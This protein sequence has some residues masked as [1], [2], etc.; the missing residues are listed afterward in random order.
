MPVETAALERHRVVDSE[1][2]S[3]GT[4]FIVSCGYGLPDQ[5][6]AIVE[7]ERMTECLPGEIGEIWLSSPSVA[8]GYWNRSEETAQTFKAHLADTN[9]G[10]YLR[11]GDLGF[12]HDGELFVTGRRKDPD[13][14]A[15]P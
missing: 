11:T 7:P 4:R 14:R 1:A 12:L 15:W 5:K 13:H 9:E 8:G 3:D 10:P 2:G 6:I